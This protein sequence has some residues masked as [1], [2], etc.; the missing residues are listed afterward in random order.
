MV[1]SAEKARP[2]TLSKPTR[3]KT[4]VSNPRGNPKSID[5]TTL[6]VARRPST[7]TVL[8]ARKMKC[9]NVLETLVA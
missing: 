3:S 8:E 7:L 5:N 1:N 2:Q 6:D 9:R 4:L